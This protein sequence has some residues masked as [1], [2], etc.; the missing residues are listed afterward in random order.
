MMIPNSGRRIAP[1][2]HGGTT[3]VCRLWL[4]WTWILTWILIVEESAGPHASG[5]YLNKNMVAA[6]PRLRY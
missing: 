5:L 6:W 4:G 2:M 3:T 1:A